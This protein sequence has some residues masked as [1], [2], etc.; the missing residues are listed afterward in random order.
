MQDEIGVEDNES[1]SEMKSVNAE[2][3][4][5]CDFVCFSNLLSVNA[6]K[7]HEIKSLT[8]I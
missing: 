2:I 3:H 7:F 8:S 1:A 6:T 4:E 5:W